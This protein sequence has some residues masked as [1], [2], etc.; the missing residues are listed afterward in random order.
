M[1]AE[2]IDVGTLDLGSALEQMRNER[3]GNYVR[4][5]VDLWHGDDPACDCYQP[6]ISLAYRNSRFPGAIW[7]V[8]VWAGEYL[9]DPTRSELA[10]A[11]RELEDARQR[12]V[13]DSGHYRYRAELERLASR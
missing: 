3:C 12:F 13:D 11:R 4:T 10:V 5:E 2:P 8:G 6:R 7:Y 9:F 1:M